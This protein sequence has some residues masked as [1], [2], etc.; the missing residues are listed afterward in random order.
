MS[1]LLKENFRHLSEKARGDGI[2]IEMLV[3][4]GDA[5]SLSYQKGSLDKFSSTSSQMVG[6]RLVDGST[7]A[8]ASTEN[9]S[10]EALL[11]TYQQ[12]KENLQIL[13]QGSGGAA[14]P[15]AEPGPLTDSMDDLYRPQQ[16]EMSDK[17]AKARDLE[18]KALAQDPRVESVPYTI[19]SERTSFQKIFN[20]RGLFRESR[21]SGYSGYAY[22]L[23]K[24][25]ESA[26]TSG[27]FFFT[28]DFHDVDA[29]A[30]AIEAVRKTAAQ[31]GA[32]RW[33]STRLPVL[34][35]REAMGTFLEM[36]LDFFSAKSVKQS[37]S[38][39]AGK[40]GQA[41]ASPIITLVDDPFDRRGANC[42][43]FDDEG[44]ASRRTVLIE[45]GILQNYLTNMELAAAMGLPHT[46]S[47][48]RSPASEMG[49]STS[50]VLIPPGTRGAEEILRTE[51]RI[52]HLTDVKAGLHVGF[53]ASSGDFSLPVEGFIYENGINQG[54]VEQIVVSGNIL[55]LLLKVKEVS[56]DLCKPGQGA[57]VPDFLIE[58]LSIAGS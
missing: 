14:I 6:L 41:I 52:L 3:T 43:P 24:E 38:L 39:F 46:A 15:L 1:D 19:F 53:K 17:L 32:R 56:R 13:K 27:D 40:K 2:E 44:A 18:A 10:L 51:P 31:L 22:V 42:R 9:P 4:G 33:P 55:D 21:S 16:V 58:E 28:R 8:Y 36:F 23:M 29:G 48:A 35:D 45:N 5:L 11:R 49:I 50:N 7:Q 12:A 34:I 37:K 25:G 30:V 26:K 57:I 47:A 54:P 20:S